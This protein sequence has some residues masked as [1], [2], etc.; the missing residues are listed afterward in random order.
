MAATARVR[1]FSGDG[2]STRPHVR[3]WQP[4]VSTGA[5]WSSCRRL[6]ICLDARGALLSFFL[7]VGSVGLLPRFVGHHDP[8]VSLPVGAPK[9]GPRYAFLPFG[10]GARTCIGQRLAVL[11]AIQ[12]LGRWV[13]LTVVLFSL[14][15]ALFAKHA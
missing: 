2:P 8:H 13:W 5:A 3:Q 7:W 6:L 11:E 1:L 9:N 12:L 15:V 14:S 10:A 4:G